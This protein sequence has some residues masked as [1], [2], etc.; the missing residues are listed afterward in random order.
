MALSPMISSAAVPIGR[1]WRRWTKYDAIALPRELPQTALADHIV[2][3][4]YGRSG[5][6]VTRVLRAAGIPIVLAEWDHAAFTDA[7]AA[8]LE[9][10]WGDIAQDV[11]LHAT[12]VE[13]AR[14][15]ILTV[16]D[17]STIRLA[18]S[19]ARAINPKV[20]VIARAAG[21]HD[22]PELRSAGVDRVIQPEF[23]GGVEMVRQALVAWDYDRSE[24]WRLIK[25]L[26]AELYGTKTSALEESAI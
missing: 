20:I 26:R 1:L 7:S 10:I 15:I 19:R 25:I 8:G 17:H 14:M 21:E 22:V 4:G 6:A 2:V 24:T 5:R 23:E 18:T 3:A 16:P 9:G 13:N 12:G 11:I